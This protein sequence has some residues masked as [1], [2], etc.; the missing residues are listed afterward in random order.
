MCLLELGDEKHQAEVSEL[1]EKVP[2]LRQ[3]IAGKS[4][5]IEK[6]VA[7]KARKYK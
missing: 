4:I 5:P 2:N 7:R 3:R 1:M 6:F